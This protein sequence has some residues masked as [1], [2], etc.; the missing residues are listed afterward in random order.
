[1]SY[2]L[3]CHS[4]NWLYFTVAT[5]FRY[6]SL[7]TENGPLRDLASAMARELSVGLAVSVHLHDDAVSDLLGILVLAVVVDKLSLWIYQVLDDSVI[8]LK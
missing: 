5:I 2:A 3:V 8:H 1:M 7:H 6:K 4:S